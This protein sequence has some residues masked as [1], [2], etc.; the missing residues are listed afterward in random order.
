MT[1][2]RRF[3]FASVTVGFRWLKRIVL[4]TIIILA[5]ADMVLARPQRI[6]SI[7]ICAD[8]LVLELAPRP[9][10]ASVS[11]LADDPYYSPKAQE[12]KGIPVN[13]GKA[14]EVIGFQADLVIAG[15]YN[16]S[17]TVNLLRALGYPVI[18]LDMPTSVAQTRQQIRL[19]AAAFGETARGESVIDR[20][21]ARLKAVS[22]V[23]D[24]HRPLAVLYQ[25][26]GFTAGPSS[27]ADELLGWAGID[28]AAARAGIR[29][30][31]NLALERLLL[32]RPDI[33]IFEQGDERG[34]ALAQQ[35]LRHPALE[36]L[37]AQVMTLTMPSR[38]WSCAGPWI[39]ETVESLANA[40]RA[41][42]AQ[43]ATLGRHASER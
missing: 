23:V 39:A 3:W 41:W 20:L 25:P 10:I 35:L 42:S 1:V 7:N 18:K 24:A 13:H 31:G 9:S 27:L 26:N 4:V 8:A 12:A 33:L 36:H 16:E 19:L 14:E 6:V 38:Y 43:H 37:E 15:E 21:D 34:P 28:N 40:R 22:E 30:W 11:F 29:F 32:A 2:Q 17:N 5:T